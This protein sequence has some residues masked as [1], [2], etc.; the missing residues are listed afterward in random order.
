MSQTLAPIILFTYNR[1]WHTQQTIETLKKNTLAMDSEIFI[2]SDGP[3]KGDEDKVNQVRGYLKNVDG[4]KRITIIERDENLGL[5]DSI[6][7]GVTKIVN[8]HEKVIIM[9]DDLLTSPYFLKFMNDS[10]SFYENDS[11]VWHISGWT[12]PI[13]TS[14]LDDNF[15]WQ[16]MDCWGWA[17]W[18]NRWSSF[19]KKPNKLIKE[20]DKRKIYKFD[21]DGSGVFWSQI[22]NNASGRINTWAIF[23][24]ATIFDNNGL[25]LTPAQ[26]YVRNIG[27]DGSG[28]HCGD[29][30]IFKSEI[31]NLNPNIKLKSNI[32]CSEKAQIRLKEFYKSKRKSWDQYFIDI[33]KNIPFIRVILKKI[34]CKLKPVKWKNL[35]NLTPIS[36]VFGLDRGTPIDRVYIDDFIKKNKHLVTGRVCEIAER[37]YSERYGGDIEKIDILNYVANE[38]A[39]I[40]GDLTKFN[41]LPSNC[42]DCF[43]L[44]QTLNFIYDYRKAIEGIHYMLADNGV[45]LITVAGISQVSR[46]DMDRWGDY[47]RFT[48]L[49]IKCVFS[50][51]FG[52]DN[53]EV[54]VYGNVLAATS[55]M[56]GISAEELTFQ[57]LFFKDPDFQVTIVVKAI[58]RK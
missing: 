1:L 22:K 17:T 14:G 53:I 24:Y 58:K 20:W 12:C 32:I 50:E 3:K 56:Q 33:M 44:T 38:N 41:T 35:R 16:V 39:S 2:F 21:L 40:V 19:Q 23:W 6:I 25:C 31:L 26:S 30:D 54:N 13:N 49:S 37:I 45:A 57:E 48:D 15:F 10:L 11:K 5:A 29:V 4:F 28:V 36:P 34:R 51:V 55:F 43:I 47:W 52:G 42:I 9:E 46:Y 18:K 27:L 8:E 7:E